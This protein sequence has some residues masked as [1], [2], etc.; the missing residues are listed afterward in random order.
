MRGTAAELACRMIASE[1]EI[2]IKALH[3]SDTIIIQ[4]QHLHSVHP[5]STSRH[6]YLHLQYEAVCSSAVIRRCVGACQTWTLWRRRLRRARSRNGGGEQASSDSD[7]QAGR[8]TATT[9]H[10]RARTQASGRA[11]RPAVRCQCARTSASAHSRHQDHLRAH[12]E[13][14]TRAHREEDPVPSG[15]ACAHQGGSTETLSSP[16][17][18]LQAHLY[19]FQAL[20]TSFIHESRASVDS[21]RMSLLI[22]CYCCCSCFVY[23]CF[24]IKL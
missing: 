3:R 10:P 18:R 5:L 7:I 8:C 14:N 11:R 19:T 9:R 6:R 20:I 23:H 15:E 4:Q 16:C 22:F 2:S 13:T 17:A 21:Q 12:R 1:S 24:I